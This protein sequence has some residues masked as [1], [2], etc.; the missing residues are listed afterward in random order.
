MRGEKEG[1]LK[2]WTGEKVSNKTSIVCGF[3]DRE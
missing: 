1:R 2:K 3:A